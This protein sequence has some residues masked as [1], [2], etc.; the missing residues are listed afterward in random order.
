[1]KYK[2]IDIDVNQ[3][4]K[5]KLIRKRKERTTDILSVV[6]M[7]LMIGILLAIIPTIVTICSPSDEKYVTFVVTF[8]INSAVL[9]IGLSLL[10]FVARLQSKRRIKYLPLDK[11]T[12]QNLNIHTIEDYCKFLNE[13]LFVT[14]F[15]KEVKDNLPFGDI[16]EIPKEMLEE[17]NSNFHVEDG[18]IAWS[19]LC[20]AYYVLKEDCKSESWAS[21]CSQC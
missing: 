2:D 19:D 14:P 21:T 20:S 3:E 13:F 17:I 4:T 5:E 11:E 16:T 15:G 8:I 18:R 9:L 12:M 1:M 6:L 7:L 10:H